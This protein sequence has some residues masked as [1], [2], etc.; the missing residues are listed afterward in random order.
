MS[1]DSR[2]ADVHLVEVDGSK[3]GDLSRARALVGIVDSLAPSRRKSLCS[4][5]AL[6]VDLRIE[7]GRLVAA[8]VHSA[9]GRERRS[10]QASGTAWSRCRD[11][12]I[13]GQY[14]IDMLDTFATLLDA[15][16][17]ISGTPP[18]VVPVFDGVPRMLIGDTGWLI[19]G[20]PWSG[21]SQ[22]PL[23]TSRRVSLS[24]VLEALEEHAGALDSQLLE[25]LNRHMRENRKPNQP[26]KDFFRALASDLRHARTDD[27]KTAAYESAL[28]SR[29][30]RALETEVGDEREFAAR[31]LGEEVLRAVR[32]Q[33]DLERALEAVDGME[34]RSRESMVR[35]TDRAGSQWFD[36]DLRP[37]GEGVVETPEPLD[38]DRRFVVGDMD[39][40]V[41][42]LNRGELDLANARIA[43]TAR[44]A[45]EESLAA[46]EAPQVSIRRGRWNSLER[47]WAYAV[48]ASAIDD[49]L[50]THLLVRIEIDGQSNERLE[51]LHW[52]SAEGV[53]SARCAL[54]VPPSRD[55]KA[56]A[57]LVWSRDD[58]SAAGPSA[59]FAYATTPRRP[60]EFASTLN[61]LRGG[62]HTDQSPEMKHV[63]ARSRRKA[64]RVVLA[65]VVSIAVTSMT[66]LF[67]TEIT[68]LVEG[69][70]SLFGSAPAEIM[71]N[72]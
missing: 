18:I 15:D 25:R 54:R 59:Q 68:A 32:D 50:A 67:W 16:A 45:L 49:R 34:R 55:I 71:V 57:S 51:P 56:S 41:R 47:R 65:C 37:P 33:R 8:F 9:W 66:Y 5:I 58:L 36:L 30:A 70:L 6:P 23:G 3:P 31:V 39:W 4:S 22:L 13:R 29:S 12:D 63:V 69:L 53:R 1:A 64:L 52:A 60:S 28:Q 24:N 11:T 62:D 43:T 27:A 14:L 72:R 46:S 26:H 21:S 61:N 2:S 42:R 7:G 19:S 48:E 44:A 20:E 40:I 10:T 35:A 38:L 17:L